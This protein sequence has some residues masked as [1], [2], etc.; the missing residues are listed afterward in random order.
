M[1]NFGCLSYI[2]II[3]ATGLFV[4][5]LAFCYLATAETVVVKMADDNLIVGEVDAQTD[6]TRLWL[7]REAAGI[8]LISGFDWADV[9]TIWRGDRPFTP[10]DF[11]QQITATK[12]PSKAYLEI[13]PYAAQ[14][15][16]E[17]VPPP[18]CRRDHELPRL[19]S[20]HIEAHRARWGNGVAADGLQIVVWPLSQYGEVVPVRGQLDLRLVVERLSQRGDNG[21]WQTEFYEIES[22]SE[23]VHEGDF[24]RGPAVYHLPFTRFHPDSDREVERQALVYARLGIPGQGVWEAS[25]PQ[26]SLRERSIF[27]E[28][29]GDHTGRSFWRGENV[30]LPRPRGYDFLRPF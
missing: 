27:R 22:G 13:S 25:D 17:C 28:Q 18:M 8:Q 19:Q 26:V 4:L 2:R 29:L 15:A 5:E 20:L 9:R 1:R 12:T 10:R 21:S 30:V 6:T 24:S 3:A 16:V 7:R 23:L 14:P 11:Q